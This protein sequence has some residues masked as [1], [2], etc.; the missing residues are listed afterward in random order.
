MARDRAALILTGGGARAAYQVGVMRAIGEMVPPKAPSPF[1]IVCGTSAGAINATSAAAGADDFGKAVAGLEAIWS[2]LFV[3]DIYRADFLHFAQ[4]SGRW[5]LSLFPAAPPR[6]S[7]AL[8]DNSPLARLLEREID[9]AAIRRR[10][11]DGS[12]DALA[13]TAASYRTGMSVSFCAAADDVPMWKRAQ[14]VG[15]GADIG[16]PHLLASSAIPFVFAPV[17]IGDEY[18]GDGAMRQLTPTAPALHLGAVR[19]LVIG[20]A[21]SGTTAD[22]EPSDATPGKPPRPPSAAQIGGHA[23]SSIFADALGTDLEKVRLVSAAARQIPPD[24]LASSPVPLRDVEMMV[25][26]PSQPLETLALDHVSAL[27]PT[28]RMVLRHIG[29][30]RAEGAGLLSYLLFES[31][32]CKALIALGYRDAQDRREELVRHL[33]LPEPAAVDLH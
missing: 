1:R 10:I 29:G 7:I 11:R 4:R 3:G 17:K 23:L 8:L 30:T 19:I 31:G 26:T 15:I 12:L 16:P 21:R 25:I 2:R 24:R 18:F 33:T 22:G 27:P 13:I 28:L 20:A 32:Y 5:L 6:S 9:F 14:R